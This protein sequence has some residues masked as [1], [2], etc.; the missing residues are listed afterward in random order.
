MYTPVYKRVKQE[1]ILLVGLI[2]GP[3]EPKLSVNYFLKPLVDEL[4]E[5]L[6]GVPLLVGRE[7]SPIITRC[8]LLCVACDLPASRKVCGFLSYSA[9]IGCSRCYKEF[10]GG[11]G[12]KNYAGFDRNMWRP[13]CVDQHRYHVHEI[14][15]T[16]GVQKKRTC[17]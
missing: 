15:T 14:Q 1:N 7:Q 13:R 6:D 4:L 8:A 17:Y 5:L 11:V 10:P 3:T 16:K 12:K 2:P 9:T